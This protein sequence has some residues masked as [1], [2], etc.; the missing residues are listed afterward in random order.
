[1]DTHDDCLPA[2]P[3]RLC[4]DFTGRVASFWEW[5]WAINDTYLQSTYL[6]FKVIVAGVLLKNRSNYSKCLCSVE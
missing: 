6:N 4:F 2:F 1:M 5:F 3:S